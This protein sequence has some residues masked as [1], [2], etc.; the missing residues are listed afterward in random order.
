MGVFLRVARSSTEGG[1]WVVRVRFGE[2]WTYIGET[3]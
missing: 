2:L 3:C 1:G